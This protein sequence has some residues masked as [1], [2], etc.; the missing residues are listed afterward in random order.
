MA[1]AGPK[2]T[3]AT[4]RSKLAQS[5]PV[6]SFLTLEAKLI[7]PPRTGRHTTKEAAAKRPMLPPKFK[8]GD[9]VI[10]T[11]R[12]FELREIITQLPVTDAGER[13]YRI[14]PPPMRSRDGTVI[15]A[16]AQAKQ[17][18]VGEN[19]LMK[20]EEL[21]DEL[22]DRLDDVKATGNDLLA[23]LW[24]AR[25]DYYQLT[26]NLPPP[27]LVGHLEKSIETTWKLLAELTTKYGIP[28]NALCKIGAGIVD[29]S[30]LPVEIP[31]LIPFEIQTLKT[32]QLG[33]PFEGT[34]IVR[35]QNLLRCW[36]GTIKKVPRKKRYG[37]PKEY[38]IAIVEHAVQFC[39]QHSTTKP[40]TD[41]K[42]PIYGFAEQFY[43]R[44][45]G[46]EPDSSLEYQIRAVLSRTS[47]RTSRRTGD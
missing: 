42:N 23:A 43:T 3:A 31:E 6:S 35:I 2:N 8:V 15:K 39:C 28:N 33:P 17:R 11:D 36:H 25:I 14:G 40:S 1:K 47:G 12:P 27:K 34:A 4:Q 44:V 26:K 7:N 21:L 13:Q 16:P 46:T 38:K 32:F 9:E 5:R 29:V 30:P 20:L 22:L 41:P 37:Q 10:R 19:Q 45:T 18:N 24:R